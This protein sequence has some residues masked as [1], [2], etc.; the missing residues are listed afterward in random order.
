MLTDCLDGEL[1]HA[2]QL[3]EALESE[4]EALGLGTYAHAT[5]SLYLWRT[6][7]HLGSWDKCVAGLREALEQVAPS[8]IRVWGFS[9]VLSAQLA[10]CLAHAG[11]VQDANTIVECLLQARS[12]GAAEDET[13]MPILVS[14]L[15]TAV[16]LTDATAL[17]RLVEP[18]T[19]AA[20]LVCVDN[21]MTVV[22]RHLA[23]AMAVLGDASAAIAY[24]RQAIEVAERVRFRP[25]LALARLQLAELLSVAPDDALLSEL[26]SMRMQP[27]LDRAREL[28]L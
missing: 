21:T 1:A 28:A 10:L 26:E 19:V 17:R 9:G 24:T 27:A 20:A 18:L 25:E 12:I 3:G 6:Q 15:E 2:V 22:A 5:A 23:A 4:A 13:S 14:L 7:I 11:R 8:D 16:L